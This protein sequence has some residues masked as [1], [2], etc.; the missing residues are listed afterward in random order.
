M[1]D[2]SLVCQILGGED[3]CGADTGECGPCPS[4]QDGKCDEPEGTG[5]CPEGTDAEDCRTV[6]GDCAYEDD[7]RC[8]EPE[9]T[10]FCPEDSDPVDCGE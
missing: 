9:G 3:P 4:R 10:G 2:E 8:D 1:G 7:G 5:L 6:P